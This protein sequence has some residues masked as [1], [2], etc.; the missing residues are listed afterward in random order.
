MLGYLGIW[1][2]HRYLSLTRFCFQSNATNAQ[3][4]IFNPIFSLSLRFA[5]GIAQALDCFV[6]INYITAA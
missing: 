4:H 3:D 2:G 6:D 5:Y 1:S